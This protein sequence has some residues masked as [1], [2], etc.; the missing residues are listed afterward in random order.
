[1]IV[2][3]RILFIAFVVMSFSACHFTNDYEKVFKDPTL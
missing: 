3:T 1:M 2:M